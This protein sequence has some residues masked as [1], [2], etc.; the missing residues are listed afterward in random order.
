MPSLTGITALDVGIGL[1]FLY[2]LLSLLC[3]VVMEAIAGVLDLRAKTL[4]D[5]LKNLLDDR[6][7]SGVGGAP[8]DVSETPAAASGQSVQRG[9]R[10]LTLTDEVLGHG[11]IRTQYKAAGLFVR[12]NRRGPSYLPS[13]MFALAL[14]DVVAPESR[15]GDSMEKVRTTLATADIPQGTKNAL[16]ALAGDAG[17]SRYRFRELV[18]QWFDGAMCRVSGWYKRK[19]QL[20]VCALSLL[21]V[22]ALNVNTIAIAD[23]LVRDDV[24]RAAVVTEATKPAAEPAAGSDQATRVEQ[25]PEQPAPGSTASL[26]DVAEQISN[27]QKLGVPLGWNVP[28]G[29]P[30]E[31]GLNLTTVGGWLI[32][33]LALS[34]GAP[35][36][37]DALARLGALRSFGTKPKTATPEPGVTAR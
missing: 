23:R 1:A 19:S 34:L 32:T 10:A 27:V 5:G 4:E 33:F 6:G 37:F 35:F 11:L 13:R 20:I 8:A 9:A 22:I 16:L 2:L 15:A 28:E 25:P 17:D 30:A 12:R 36:W 21:V 24:V 31:P 26:D 18:E 29:D 14:L 3:A 7:T